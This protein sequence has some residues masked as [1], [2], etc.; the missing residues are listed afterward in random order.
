MFT[1]LDSGYDDVEL[2]YILIYIYCLEIVC[3]ARRKVGCFAHVAHKRAGRD[4]EGAVGSPE[5]HAPVV[6]VFDDVV[7]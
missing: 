5:V 3:I 6:A 2:Y 4:D 7:A 1:V